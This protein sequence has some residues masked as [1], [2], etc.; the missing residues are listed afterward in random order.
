MFSLTGTVWELSTTV[1][2]AERVGL[3]A[4]GSTV[5][6]RSSSH[7]VVVTAAPD[8]RT[9]NWDIYVTSLRGC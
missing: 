3:P 4:D 7:P 6:H 8:E 9:D 5:S 2:T 1:A